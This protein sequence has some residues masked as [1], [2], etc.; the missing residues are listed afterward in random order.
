MAKRSVIGLEI[1]KAVLEDLPR[2]LELYAQAREFMVNTGN[3]RQWARRNWPPEEL[4][5][6]DISV[7]KCH[8]CWENGRILAVFYY[9][10]GLDIDPT[11]RK[12]EGEGWADH[13][14][15]GVVHR[16]AAQAGSGAG[17]FCLRWAIEQSGSLRIDTHGDNKVMQKVLESLGFTKRGIIYVAEDNDPR[18]AYEI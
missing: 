8:V 15:Y 5:R 4:I 1:R 11:Y 10:F 12:I 17:K 14:P 9:D 3:P 18:Y 7:G 16:I 2:I 6:K 13:G